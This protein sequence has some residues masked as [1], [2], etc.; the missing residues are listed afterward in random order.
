MVASVPSAT[1]YAEQIVKTEA[2]RQEAQFADGVK[3][4]HV[5]GAKVLDGKR[6]AVL[7]FTL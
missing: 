6:I 3:G 4:L 7:P 2:F 1:T 5:Y